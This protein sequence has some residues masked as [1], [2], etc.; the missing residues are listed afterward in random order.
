MD[1]QDL[2]MISWIRLGFPWSRRQGSLR[3][4]YNHLEMCTLKR[5]LQDFWADLCL[6]R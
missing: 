6:E 3:I 5:M 2:S 1:F 4:A